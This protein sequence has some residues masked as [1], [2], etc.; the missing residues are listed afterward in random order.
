[1]ARQRYDI[2]SHWLLHNQGQGALLVGGL[3]I[4]SRD[5]SIQSRE[6][7]PGDWARSLMRRGC[8]DSTCSR[9]RVPTWRR[10]AKRSSR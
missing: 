10:S 2:S 1:M 3:S 4:F 5:A 6:T 9:P 7:L 8:G